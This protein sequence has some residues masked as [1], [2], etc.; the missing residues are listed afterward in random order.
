M[1]W[2]AA[3]RS[4]RQAAVVLFQRLCESEP[5]PKAKFAKQV[6]IILALFVCL[7]TRACARHTKQLSFRIKSNLTEARASEASESCSDPWSAQ[8]LLHLST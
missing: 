5:L 1:P 8:V 3:V 4:F 7:K 6:S 2:H